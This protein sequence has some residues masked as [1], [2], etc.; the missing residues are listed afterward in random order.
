MI[1]FVHKSKK[2]GGATNSSFLALIPKENGASTL[3]RF[4]PISLIIL[5]IKSWEKSLLIG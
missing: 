3:E 5:L 4:R 2:M 1:K